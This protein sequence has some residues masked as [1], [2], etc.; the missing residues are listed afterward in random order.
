MESFIYSPMLPENVRG[1]RYEGLYHVSDWFPTILG[2]VNVKFTPK[3]GFEL[4]GFDQY[5]ALL[6]LTTAAEGA[7]VDGKEGVRGQGQGLGGGGFSLSS[8]SSRDNSRG[9]SSADKDKY[10]GLLPPYKTLTS[11]SSSSSSAAAATASYPRA[12]VLYNY[13]YNV[14]GQAFDFMT[15]FV[16]ASYYPVPHRTNLSDIKTMNS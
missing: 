10:T 12:Y 14:E 2:M 15:R 6:T 4:D 5:N 9:L 7:E 8:V 16:V 13:Y 1:G 11:S 3:T